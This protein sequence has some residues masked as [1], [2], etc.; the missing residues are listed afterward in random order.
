MEG[1]ISLGV[2]G[3]FTNFPDLLAE[4][5]VPN[6]GSPPLLPLVIASGAFAVCARLAIF[7][8]WLLL[9]GCDSSSL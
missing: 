7:G 6:T 1:L 5:E 2:D 3:M 8:G 9:R 4:L